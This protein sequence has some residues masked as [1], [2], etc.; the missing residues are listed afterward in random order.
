MLICRAQLHN[1][2]NVLTFRMSSERTDTSS[3]PA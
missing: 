1:T 3:S 2:S